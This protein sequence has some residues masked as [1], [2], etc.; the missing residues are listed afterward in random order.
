MALLLLLELE[1]QLEE[2]VQGKGFSI[3]GECFGSTVLKRWGRRVWIYKLELG[4]EAV[5]IVDKRSDV[6]QELEGAIALRLIFALD[7]GVGVDDGR[8]LQ[9]RGPGGVDSIEGMILEGRCVQEEGAI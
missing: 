8:E 5:K 1:L 4:N 6:F 3:L 9:R 2:K 7:L